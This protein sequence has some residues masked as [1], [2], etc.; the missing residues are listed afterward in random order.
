M[1]EYAVFYGVRARSFSGENYPRRI[2]RHEQSNCDNCCIE[3][4][5][6]GTLLSRSLEKVMLMLGRTWK[7]ELYRIVK[8]RGSSGFTS[9]HSFMVLK[10]TSSLQCA[11][12][13]QSARCFD[14]ALM[15]DRH[16][17]PTARPENA[18]NTLQTFHPRCLHLHCF[19]NTGYET[20]IHSFCH[21]S[22]YTPCASCVLNDCTFSCFPT[23]GR[24]FT[25]S[26]TT[27]RLHFDRQSS[28]RLNHQQ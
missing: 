14:T 12:V 22:S 10:S 17:T 18:T 25:L 7:R 8:I 21:S 24:T 2:I 5:A 15:R 3:V 23:R 1:V 20:T 26:I 28:K 6:C 27:V 4:L 9:F 16:L 11:Q 19:S 13:P